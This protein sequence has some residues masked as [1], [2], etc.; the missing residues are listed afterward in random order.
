MPYR[1]PTA[2]DG[3]AAASAAAAPS[4]HRPKITKIAT[5]LARGATSPH[6]PAWRAVRFDRKQP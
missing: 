6:G 4:G 1:P 5:L 3:A 2:D